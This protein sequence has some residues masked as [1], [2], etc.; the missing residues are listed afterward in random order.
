MERSADM[1]LKTNL[2]KI[3]LSLVLLLTPLLI[4]GGVYVV[5]SN[6][7]DSQENEPDANWTNLERQVF[8]QIRNFPGTSGIYIKD[9]KR[10]W[11]IEHNSDKLFP[12]ASLVKIPLMAVLYQV[13]AE[14]RISFDEVLPLQRR[15]KT[16]GSGKLKFLKT[17]T[18]LSIRQ[19]VFK[20]IT[21]SDNTATNM[22][23]DLLGLDYF[24][25]YF[26]RLGL[27][28]TN[29]SRTVMD[30]KKRDE[31]I[32]NYTTPKDMGKIL[33]MIYFKELT[34]SDE[35]LEILKSQKINDRLG[36]GIPRT[37]P[38][39]HKTGLMKNSCHDVGI[40]FAPTTDYVICALTSDIRNFKRAKS[41]IS[42]IGHITAL[43]YSDPSM[44]PAVKRSIWSKLRQK[45][46]A[47]TG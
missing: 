38:I 1:K 19:L 24:N 6:N 46:S 47:K 41:F 2:K 29:F 25:N 23:T 7:F 30:L 44:H 42:K 20:M 21:E 43:Y 14:G 17:G 4:G 15:F 8:Y 40:V 27:T 31:G 32:E 5:Q 18:R 9:L 33:E 35:M 12:S 28:R 10:N 37:W 13:Q 39:G 34:S 22:L 36:I 11:V 26:M 3:L 45:L 16:A